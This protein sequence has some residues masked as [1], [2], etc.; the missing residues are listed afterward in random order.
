[1]V[2]GVD[3]ATGTV[4]LKARG[5]DADSDEMTL[6]T[7]STRTV[8]VKKWPKFHTKAEGRSDMSTCPSGHQSN[9][10]D[11]CEICG[12]RMA[13]PNLSSPSPA[14]PY[15]RPY[16][17]SYEL[18][19]E[20]KPTYEPAH[21]QPYE[22]SYEQPYKQPYASVPGPAG[23]SPA[24]APKPEPC[25]I[26]GTPREGMPQYCEECRYDFVPHAGTQF[27]PPSPPSPPSPPACPPPYQQ[28]ESERSRPSQV[29]RPAEP[30]TP[31]AITTGSGEFLLSP[32]TRPDPQRP[33]AAT[34]SWTAVVAAD[35]D[36]FTA[37]MA[38]SGPEGQ[39]LFFPEYSPEHR[40]PL[41]G[42]QVTV[43]RHRHSTGES[44]DIDLSHAPEDPGVSHRHAVLVEQPDG[45][46]SVLDQDSTNGTTVNGGEEPID[47]F[48]PVPLKDGDRV[49]VGAWTTITIVRE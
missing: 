18:S 1:M 26:C 49:H 45:T 21:E 8:R 14:A 20:P 15:A 17:P 32:P 27:I 29:K 13:S 11:W 24:A 4:R 41:T 23:R 39:G 6:K 10:D 9:T 47:P 2:D 35:R 37:M 25:P 44:P 19:Y 43:G 33:P 7:R 3:G 40:L 12:R 34:G 38:R 22:A 46:W 48:V 16:E 31:D 42:G 5:S 36:Y 30:L 28:Y